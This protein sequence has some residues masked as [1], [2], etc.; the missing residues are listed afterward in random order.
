MPN[1]TVVKAGTGGPWWKTTAGHQKRDGPLVGGGY[2]AKATLAGYVVIQ[3]GRR[4]CV[5]LLGGGLAQASHWPDGSD[6]WA[7]PGDV[8]VLRLRW[9]AMNGR[10]K[11]SREKLPP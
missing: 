10:D 11:A 9:L 1:T 7:L 8:V 6:G 4:V 5:A 2:F 3:A